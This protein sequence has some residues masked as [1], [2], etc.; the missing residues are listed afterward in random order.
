MLLRR[1]HAAGLRDVT[2]VEPVDGGMAP[3]AGIATQRG[4][5]ALFVKSFDTTPADDLFAAEAEGLDV[6]ANSVASPRQRSFG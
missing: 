3:L 1:L 6:R 4:G 5:P 2:A